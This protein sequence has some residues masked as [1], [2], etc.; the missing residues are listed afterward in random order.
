MRKCCCC[1]SVH[2]GSLLLGILG[3]LICALELVVIIPFLLDCE[4][5]NPIEEN[6]RQF[7]YIV[8]KM[9]Q[10]QLNMTS[11]ETQE[12]V[13]HGEE[14][15]STAMLVEAASAGIYLVVCLLMVIGV[16][17]RSRCLMLP[18][19]IVQMFVSVV[20]ALVGGAITVILFMYFPWALGL[21]SLVVFLVATFLF[22][23]FW[24]AVQKAFVE[25]GNR[26]YMYSPAPM[27]P[28]YNPKDRRYQP[29]AP[30]QFSMD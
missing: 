3:L 29:S 18:Y 9:L 24:C 6:S 15:L 27:K 13:A 26:D 10:E 21:I 2:V 12:I 25:L 23:Y 14:W 4:E 1:I 16:G 20:F 22:I 8:E 30:Q 5:F 7:F 19:L 17:C 28:I 11:N